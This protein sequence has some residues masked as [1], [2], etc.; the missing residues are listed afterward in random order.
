MSK[1]ELKRKAAKIAEKCSKDISSEDL[2]LEMNH[3]T[4]VHNDIF[5]RKQLGAFKLRNALAEYRLQSIFLNLS[6]SLGM[7]ITAPDTVA[8]AGATASLSL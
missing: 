5:C 2:V 1:Q 4:M 6:D 8:L 3:I 7:F